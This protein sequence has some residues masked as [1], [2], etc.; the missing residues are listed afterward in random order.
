MDI[1]IISETPFQTYNAINLV[2]HEFKS[3]NNRVDLFYQNYN[4]CTDEILNRI[5]KTDVFNQVYEYDFVYKKQGLKYLLSVLF[6]IFSP[7][8]YLQLALKKDVDLS[9]KQYDLLVIASGSVVDIQM[10]KLYKSANIIAYDDGIGSYTG[11]IIHKKNLKWYWR[12]IRSTDHIKPLFLYVNNVNFCRSTAAEV[13]KQMKKPYEF[14]SEY[15]K[16]I[17]FVF[18]YKDSYLYKKHNLVYLTQPIDD[19]LEDYNIVE[20]KI[21]ELLYCYRKKLIIKK[22]PRDLRTYDND[23]SIDTQNTLWEWTC[24]KDISDEHV[25]ISICSTAQ[26]T[27]KLIYNKEPY[28]VF[29]YRLYDCY[30]YYNAFNAIQSTIK[31]ITDLYIKK[32]KIFTPNSIDELKNIIQYKI[33]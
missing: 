18:N 5:K 9:L 27:P 21:N 28:L 1:A 17:D 33:K 6:Q 8:Y 3:P 25:L 26:I 31:N 20:E 19:L 24:N 15:I 29:T 2:M 10:T 16:L 30:K 13:I 23:F 4:K 12:L 32:E 22:H 11:D 7:K 14:S